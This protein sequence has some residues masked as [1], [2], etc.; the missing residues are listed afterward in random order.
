MRNATDAV[1]IACPFIHRKPQN[2]PSLDDDDKMMIWTPVPPYLAPITKAPLALV[3]SAFIHTAYTPPNPPADDT[4]TAKY[5]KKD[6]LSLNFART[7][8]FATK[9]SNYQFRVGQKTQHDIDYILDILCLRSSYRY[10]E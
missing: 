5:G 10:R 3:S 9:V 6:G 2:Y 4:E 8:G 1:Y 7:V